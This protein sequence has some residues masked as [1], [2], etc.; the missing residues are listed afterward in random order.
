M[1]EKLFDVVLI[2]LKDRVEIMKAI[3]SLTPVGLKGSKDMADNPPAVV[4]RRVSR[5]KADE[6]K[7]VLEQAGGTVEVRPS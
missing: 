4:L 7:Q 2:A 5:S 1:S 6:A 3:M